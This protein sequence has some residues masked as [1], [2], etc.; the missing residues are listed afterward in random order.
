MQ[1]APDSIM[2]SLLQPSPETL[3]PSS[4]CSCFDAR[5]P[6]PQT[7]PQMSGDEEV[8]PEHTQP[9]SN[10]HKLEHP[11]PP[12]LFPSSQFIPLLS[13]TIPSPQIS[14]HVSFE[15]GDPPWHS[16]P[17]SIVHVS[18]HP[19]LLLIFPSSHI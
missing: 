10:F 17:D 18:D 8:P 14:C 9:C 16:Y 3:F 11:S 7:V 15:I 1:A 13:K 4:H 19:S 12:I 6:S 2:Q 5:M